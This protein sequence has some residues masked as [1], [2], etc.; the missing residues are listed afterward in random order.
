MYLVS[1]IKAGDICYIP[2]TES[3]F[4]SWL[5]PWKFPVQQT[6]TYVKGIFREPK[7]GQQSVLIGADK[8]DK[9]EFSVNAAWINTYG[10]IT[11]RRIEM[12]IVDE[13]DIDKY[14]AGRTP[15]PS[16]I[17]TTNS[18]K[19]VFVSSRTPPLILAPLESS[20]SSLS[21]SALPSSID[22]NEEEYKE[23]NED[24]SICGALDDKM[25][26]EE[27]SEVPFLDPFDVIDIL[28]EDDLDLQFSL[29]PGLN[30]NPPDFAG[31]PPRGNHDTANFERFM[32]KS[33][34][35]IWETNTSKL[36]KWI[37]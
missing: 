25:N 24:N 37:I 13:A 8:F 19:G 2:I 6:N 12:Y 29:G 3:H 5:H 23:E 11:E 20:S 33:A 4:S 36:N 32:G 9:K 26:V 17:V 28:S 16:R 18:S 15:V 7:K 22:I 14:Y 21:A 30:R 35:E 34:G 31:N 1:E 27:I 10:Y